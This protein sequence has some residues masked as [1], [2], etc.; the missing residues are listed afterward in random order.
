MAAALARQTPKA[1]NMAKQVFLYSHSSS[2]PCLGLM[3][4]HEIHVNLILVAGQEAEDVWLC[5]DSA[6]ELK[7]TVKSVEF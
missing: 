7:S 1:A 2:L 3:I 5:L 6:S 4:N